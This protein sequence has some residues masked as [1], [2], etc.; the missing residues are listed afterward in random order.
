[1]AA[2]IDVFQ[3]LKGSKQYAEDISQIL[4]SGLA[5]L[6]EAYLGQYVITTSLALAPLQIVILV[7]LLKKQKLRLPKQIS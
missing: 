5:I 7:V 1:M 4:H 3:M 2:R 6:L